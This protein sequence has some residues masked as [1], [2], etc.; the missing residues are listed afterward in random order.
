MKAIILAAGLGKRMGTL[1]EER[2]K[3]LVCLLGKPL[4]ERQVEVLKADGISDIILVGGYKAEKLKTL[5]LPL[6]VNDQYASTNMVST[7]FCAS[8]QMEPGR[9]LIIAYGDIVYEKKVL[10]ALIGCQ[11]P[12]CVVV[13]KNWRKYWETRME[14]PLYDAETLKLTDGNRIIELGKKAKG[15]SEIEGQYIGLIKIA[16]AWVEKFKRAWQEMD[17]SASYDGK[18]FDNMF[19][20]S[21]LQ[22]LIDS[23]WDAQAVIVENG[24]LEIDTLSDLELYEQL[25][26]EGQLEQFYK[27]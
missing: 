22:Y 1:T 4:L 26:K 15:Y 11:A 14:D 20:T 25:Y 18:D 2:P 27:T 21:Y 19:M 23:G 6:L 7:L 17:R 3:G 24:W 12:L 8:E 13:D 16:G 5:G 9:D 10:E